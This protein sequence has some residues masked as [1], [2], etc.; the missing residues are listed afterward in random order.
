MTNF[1]TKLKE[2]LKDYDHNYSWWGR[3]EHYL[4]QILALIKKE[5]PKKERKFCEDCGD[6]YTCSCFNPTSPKYKPV[7]PLMK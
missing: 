7:K 1:R 6:I 3:E 2:I 5:L 4:D